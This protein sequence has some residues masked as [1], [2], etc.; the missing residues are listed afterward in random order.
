VATQLVKW[1]GNRPSFGAA[2]VEFARAIHPLG[3]LARTFSELIALPAETKRLKHEA[4]RETNLHSEE[5]L[6]V[7]AARYQASE[8]LA[9][10]RLAIERFFDH[11]ERELRQHAIYGNRILLALE[12]VTNL[13]SNPRSV[14]ERELAHISMIALSGHLVQAGQTGERILLGIL[15][16]S[17]LELNAL[18][19]PRANLPP[20]EGSQ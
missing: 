18:P 19:R 12:V 10:R 6:K 14:H 17:R 7:E 11:V 20:G 8:L 5:L 16:S 2:V 4:K 9:Q 1:D 13:A 3:P 15:E